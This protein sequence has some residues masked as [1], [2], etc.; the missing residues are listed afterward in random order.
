MSVRASTWNPAAPEPSVLDRFLGGSFMYVVGRGEFVKIGRSQNP[1]QRI[2]SLQTANPMRL[3]TLLIVPE[4]V[5]TEQEAHRR[6]S[7]Q[8]EK[9]EWFSRTPELVAW[10][11]EVAARARV[12]E[13][14]RE[15]VVAVIERRANPRR[16]LAELKRAEERVRRDI[17]AALQEEARQREELEKEN[18]CR[19]CRRVGMQL[20]RSET[21]RGWFCQACR[22]WLRLD[23]AELHDA[24]EKAQA[25]VDTARKRL[26]MLQ[27]RELRIA[28]LH[29]EDRNV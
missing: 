25:A 19:L 27:L 24:F 18:G 20:S 5:V 14:T 21:L 16:P 4:Y 29:R 13:R 1:A 3:E 6:W 15:R 22:R 28:D 26:A 12:A 7:S 17:A 11:D 8:R 23:G 9:G 2:S 10:L